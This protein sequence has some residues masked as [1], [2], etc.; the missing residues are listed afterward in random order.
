MKKKQTPAHLGYWVPTVWAD[1]KG[2]VAR[3]RPEFV[4]FYE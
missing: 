4:P 1:K 3:F 2:G